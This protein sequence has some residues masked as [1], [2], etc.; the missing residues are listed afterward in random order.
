MMATTPGG[1]LP[2]IGYPQAWTSGTN[3]LVSGDAVFATIDTP[4]DLA[5]WKGKLKGKIVLTT[6][7]PDVPA[8]FERA[9]A[10]LHAM[11]SSR[12]LERETDA[13]R[14][15]RTRRTGGRIPAA[16]AERRAA[17]RQTRTQFLKDEGVVAIITPAAARRHGVRRRRRIARSQR[18]RRG[19]RRDAS[20]SSTT[21][22]SSAR[23][24][25]ISRCGSRSTSRTRSTTT[26]HR[27]TSSARFPAPTRPTRSSCSA[28]TSTRGT[29]GTGATD[30]AAGSA[31]MMEAMRILKQSGLPLR[32]TVRIGL[33]GG[34]EQGL[35][36][37]RRT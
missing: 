5:T 22:A 20:P 23:C 2:V 13:T 10:A 29:R 25:R 34:E 4:E 6:A 9:G 1:S 35:I 28:R 37:S 7:M 17:L 16:A 8:L 19:A 3:G 36:G 33:W 21:A 14:P 27:S 31:V 15:R 11:T 24:R 18:A 12:D 26:R 30:N 32:R